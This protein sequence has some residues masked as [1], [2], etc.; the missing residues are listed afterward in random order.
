MKGIVQKTDY[1]WMVKTSNPCCYEMFERYIPLHND[2]NE[3]YLEDGNEVEVK[4]DFIGIS[5]IASITK[6][7]KKSESC[8]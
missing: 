6:L 1:G 7:L 5:D 8:F 4:V 2:T 3:E